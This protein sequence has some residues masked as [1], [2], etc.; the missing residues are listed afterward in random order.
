[1]NESLRKISSSIDNEESMLITEGEFLDPTKGG[2]RKEINS[3]LGY[4]NEKMMNI[5]IM[6]IFW[7]FLKSVLRVI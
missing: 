3:F 2:A 5:V 1:M 7:D 6:M 4:G